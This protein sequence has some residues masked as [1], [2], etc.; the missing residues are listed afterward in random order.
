MLAGSVSS[1]ESPAKG[2]QLRGFS[3][4]VHEHDIGGTP[5]LRLARPIRRRVLTAA[6]PPACPLPVGTGQLLGWARFGSTLHGAAAASVGAGTPRP[7]LMMASKKS[8]GRP[9]SEL[10][11]MVVTLRAMATMAHTG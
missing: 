8:E 11:K 5:E 9:H 10:T 1:R 3:R 7:T 4:H 2:G 6:A